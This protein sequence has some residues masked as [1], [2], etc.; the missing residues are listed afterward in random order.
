MDQTL[1]LQLPS[2]T[3]PPGKIMCRGIKIYSANVLFQTQCA[4]WAQKQII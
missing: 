1:A 3:E 4:H 2:V